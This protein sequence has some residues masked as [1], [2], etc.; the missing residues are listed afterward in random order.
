MSPA[1]RLV[2]LLLS[3][4]KKDCP[5]YIVHISLRTRLQISCTAWRTRLLLNLVKKLMRILVLLLA[6]LLLSADGEWKKS[7][8]RHSSMREWLH[9]PAAELA[10]QVVPL[11]APD[12]HRFHE[13]ELVLPACA[14]HF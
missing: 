14:T 10:Q 8:W 13:R 5:S 9:L 4:S 3:L 1:Q 2:Q 12:G 11:G 6:R 7:D